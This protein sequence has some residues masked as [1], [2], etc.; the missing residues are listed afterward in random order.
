MGPDTRTCITADYIS[1][2]PS[3]SAEET[4]QNGGRG[5]NLKAGQ[6]R[7]VPKA[8]MTL[9]CQGDKGG[10]GGSLT[11]KK[12]GVLNCS[13]WRWEGSSRRKGYMDTYG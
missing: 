5:L 11:M 6:R 1:H 9:I 2:K 7:S 10:E 13:L 4:D 12:L 3:L 8:V